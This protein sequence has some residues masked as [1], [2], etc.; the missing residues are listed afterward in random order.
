MAEPETDDL[1]TAA[2]RLID[3]IR[4]LTDCI[5]DDGSD[6]ERT[7]LNWAVLRSLDHY[8]NVASWTTERSPDVLEWVPELAEIEETFDDHR[9]LDRIIQ[10]ATWVFAVTD[11]EEFMRKGRENVAVYESVDADSAV[12]SVVAGRFDSE[13]DWPDFNRYADAGLRLEHMQYSTHR[14]ASEGA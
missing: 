12:A 5:L 13:I 14:V 8:R 7:Q 2:D 11:A 9:G 4:T 10:F 6:E 1:V 3:D